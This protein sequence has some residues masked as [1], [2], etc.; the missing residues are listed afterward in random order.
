MIDESRSIGLENYELVK[1]FIANYSKSLEFG[2]NATRSVYLE[3]GTFI[4]DFILFND[5]L[6]SENQENFIDAIE[7]L[8]YTLNGVTNTQAAANFTRI[9]QFTDEIQRPSSRNVAILGRCS[10]L[11]LC[12]VR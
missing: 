8:N 5:T 3:Y 4:N 6:I 7:G 12:R 10:A 9:F 11:V 2:D 1:N